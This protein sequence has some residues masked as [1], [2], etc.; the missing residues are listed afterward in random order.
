MT[1]LS[2]GVEELDKYDLERV[3]TFSGTE[4]SPGLRECHS[5][6]LKTYA[7]GGELHARTDECHLSAFQPL[8][9]TVALYLQSRPAA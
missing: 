4:E 7:R 2:E 5:W 6:V 1:R 8:H 3:F 9:Q